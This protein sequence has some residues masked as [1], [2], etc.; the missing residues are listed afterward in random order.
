M[1]PRLPHLLTRPLTLA[2]CVCA[3]SATLLLALPSPAPHLTGAAGTTRSAAGG[4]TQNTDDW[5][6]TGS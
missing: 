3:L 5:N 1:I 6:S 4:P 2:A